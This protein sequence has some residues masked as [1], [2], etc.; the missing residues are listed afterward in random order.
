LNSVGFRAERRRQRSVR[1]FGR[2]DERQEEDE[3]SQKA[4]CVL[5]YDLIA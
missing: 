4:R 3:Y 1:I 5:Y 2:R